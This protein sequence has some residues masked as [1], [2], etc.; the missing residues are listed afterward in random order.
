[1]LAVDPAPKPGLV[2]LD[3]EREEVEL[4]RET[5]LEALPHVELADVVIIDGDHNYWTVSEELRAAVGTRRRRRPPATDVP[6]QWAGRTPFVTTTS[7][8]T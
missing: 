3:E 8:P 6:R 5:S 4:L 7:T 1:M 2:Q